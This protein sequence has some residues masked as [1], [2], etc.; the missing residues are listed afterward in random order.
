MPSLK[1]GCC[2]ESFKVWSDYTDQDQDEGFGICKQ[3]QIDIEAKHNQDLDVAAMAIEKGL[4][5]DRQQAFQS[6]SA[7]SR[8]QFAGQAIADGI[9]KVSFQRVG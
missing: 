7:E 8:R 4:S 9:L 6:M 2:G 1:C 3:C 5:G